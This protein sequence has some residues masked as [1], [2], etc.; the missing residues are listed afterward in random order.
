MDALMGHFVYICLFMYLVDVQASFRCIMQLLTS[1]RMMHRS[2]IVQLL[3]GYDA[4][5]P[6][7]HYAAA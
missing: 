6:A 3:T 4:S 5:H 2:S 1:Y 7:R